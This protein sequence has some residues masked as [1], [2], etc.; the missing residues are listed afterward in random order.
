MDPSWL[1]AVAALAAFAGIAVGWL[2]GGARRGAAAARELADL[3]SRLAVLESERSGLAGRAAAAERE[4]GELE[5]RLLAE[6]GQRTAAEATARQFAAQLEALRRDLAARDDDLRTL[7]SEARA[8]GEARQQLQ[9]RLEA[10]QHAFEE[11]RQLLADAQAKLADAF[12]S[13]A[14]ES[15]RAN[16]Q[17][18]ID[19]AKAQFEQIRESARGDLEK[20]QLSIAQLVEPVRESLEKVQARIGE[21][22]KERVGAYSQLL[23]QVQTLALGQQE[24]KRETGNLVG[25]LRR[26]SVRGRWGEVQLKRVVEMAGML[27]HVDFVEQETVGTDDGDLRPDLVVKLPG[28]K[29]LVIDS[30][31]PLEAY[32]DSLELT[33]EAACRAKLAEH[34]RQIRDHV[35]KLSRKQYWDQFENTPDFVVLFIPGEVFYSAALEQDPSL[36]ET[37]I[38]Q[39]VILATPTTLI[40]LLRTVAYGWRQEALAEDARAIAALGKELYDRVATMAG[41]W[42]D[43]GQGLRKALTSYNEAVGSL[44]VRVLPSLRRFRELNI[45]GDNRRAEDK[46]ED[47][48]SI[49]FVPRELQ[50]EEMRAPAGSAAPGAPRLTVIDRGRAADGGETG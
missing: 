7:R 42:A 39:R 8:L 49:E 13:L 33:D 22:E 15:L 11:Q 35:A 17:Q 41:H 38:R 6:T 34:A 43:M 31:A 28:G 1:L 50:A 14:A 25:A 2:A 3:Q 18:F 44:E 23:Q 30:K 20:R 29:S 21:V 45:G 12:R 4:T 16:N 47:V 36:I 40:A 9:T 26:P 46:L 19:L 32:L 24:L 48:K 37:G 27:D 10:Q 5:D